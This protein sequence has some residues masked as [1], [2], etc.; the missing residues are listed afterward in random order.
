MGERV[1]IATFKSGR[2]EVIQAASLDEAHHIALQTNSQTLLGVFRSDER[3]SE[4]WRDHVE[5][6]K[7]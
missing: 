6:L 5:L 2:R 3:A 7:G 1:Y 4:D